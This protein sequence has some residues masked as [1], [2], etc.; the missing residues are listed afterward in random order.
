MVPHGHRDARPRLSAQV[1]PPPVKLDPLVVDRGEVEPVDRVTARLRGKLLAPAGVVEQPAESR[2]ASAAGS[3]RATSS[4]L[5]AWSRTSRHPSVS[6]ATSPQ[7]AAAPSSR[8]R[9]IPAAD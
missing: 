5:R 4:P 1:E 8:I 2:A 9:E 7:P 6:L 3:R